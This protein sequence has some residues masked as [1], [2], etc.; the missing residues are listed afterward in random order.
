MDTKKIA[1]YIADDLVR[2][3]RMIMASD[4]G[5]NAKVG[6]NTLV[7]SDLYRQLK[8]D[9]YNDDGGMVID[10]LFNHY[11]EFIESGRPPM[12]GKRPPIDVIEDWLKRKHI[13][14]SNENI[15]S[16]AFL[17][18][19]AIWRDGYKARKVLS[20][21]DDWTDK[22]FEEKWGDMVFDMLLEDLDKVFK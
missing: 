16:V 20:A 10:L 6:K 21:L 22:Q 1:K 2:G 12:H 11:I 14:K 5:I 18:S 17:V 19:R 7:D 15:R 8:T 9:T 4:I 3:A 13:V